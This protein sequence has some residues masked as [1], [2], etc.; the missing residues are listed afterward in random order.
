[1]QSSRDTVRQIVVIVSAVIAVVGSFIG[2]GQTSRSHGAVAL[3]THFRTE[4]MLRSWLC[5][6]AARD[7]GG[8]ASHAESLAPM[9]ACPSTFKEYPDSIRLPMLA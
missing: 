4:G 9:R 7:R 1:M 2:S 3:G 5:A 8:R 6:V